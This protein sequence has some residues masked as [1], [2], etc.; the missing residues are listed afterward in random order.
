MST[1][2]RFCATKWLNIGVGVRSIEV[3]TECRFIFQKMWE[4]NLGTQAGVHLIEDV[5][6]IRGPLNTGFAVLYRGYFM[7]GQRYQI[8]LRKNKPGKGS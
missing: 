1:Y 5:C 6:F 7:P 2:C 4:D 8:S 3:S